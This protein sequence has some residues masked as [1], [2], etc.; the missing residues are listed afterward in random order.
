MDRTTT[1]SV[2]ACL[3]VESI[4]FAR[5]YDRWGELIYE[6]LSL[7]PDCDGIGTKVWDGTFQWQI[8]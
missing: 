6:D 4:N 5:I 8:P 2:F 3:G 1:F 7:N